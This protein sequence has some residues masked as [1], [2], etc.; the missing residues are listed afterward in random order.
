M[1]KIVVYP[2][3]ILR[4]KTPEIT[5]VDAELVKNI[6][7]LKEVL[8][9]EKKHAAGL[10]AVQLGIKKR[11]FGLLRGD[12]KKLQ[13]F[14]NPNITKKFGERVRPMMVFE[15]GSQEEFLE[16]CLSFPD[17]FGTVKRYLKIEASW[18]EV[19]RNMTLHKKT[20][21]LEGIE[22]IAFQH[23]SEHLEGILFVDY[24]KREGGELYKFVGD[25][26]IKWS[27]D[28]VMEGEEPGW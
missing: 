10:A 16:G 4:V 9:E 7:E 11:F 23:E 24:I 19:G 13:I 27:V 22:A 20:A 6:G 17:L 5:A 2:N 3:K 25:K 28:K 8:A 26:K 15:D 18:E 1:R 12:K 14:I 21:V